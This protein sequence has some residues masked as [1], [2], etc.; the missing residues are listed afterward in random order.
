MRRCLLAAI[1]LC[2]GFL[3]AAAVI[4]PAYA[5]E[6][7]PA[8]APAAKEDRIDGTVKS[9]DAKTKTIFVRLRGKTLDRTVVYDDAT[10]FTFRNKPSTLDEVKIERRVICLG[11][12]TDKGV[13]NATRVDVRDEK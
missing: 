1:G 13:F 7:K 11:K 2:L 9:L 6:K 12:L 5:Q 8:A 3:F 10:K 4:T